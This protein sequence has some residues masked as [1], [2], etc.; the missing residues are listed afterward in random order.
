MKN[1]I[2]KIQPEQRADLK[3][4]YPYFIN[5]GGFVGRQ[6]FWKGSPYKLLGFSNTP[7]AGS[8]DLLV[9]NFLKSPQSAINMFPV[10]TDNLN[11]WSTLTD[12][13]GDITITPCK[14]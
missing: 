7:Q 4:P 1:Q 8:I 12:K 2:I 3:L 6:D 11:S 9:T 13:I 10:F 5:E 14:Q